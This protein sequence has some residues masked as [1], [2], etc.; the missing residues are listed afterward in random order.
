MLTIL[1]LPTNGLIDQNDAPVNIDEHVGLIILVNFWS[2]ECPFSEQ[3]D[4]EIQLAK[5]SFP[6]LHTVA[7]LSNQNEDTSIAKAIYSNRGYDQLWID[8]GAVFAQACNAETTPT[9]LIFDENGI[10]RY[11]G[12][13]N[14]RTFRKR[15][16]EVNFVQNALIQ[17]VNGIPIEPA[18]TP[19]YGCAIVEVPLDV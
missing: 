16:S 13:I 7:V 4:A 14:D 8:K 19:A 10:L 5:E 12:A 1:E 11:R 9:V 17:L 6:T 2:T 18:E 15:V 3:S